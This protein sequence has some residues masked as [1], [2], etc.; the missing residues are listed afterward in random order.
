MA[1][2]ATRIAPPKVR[3]TKNLIDGKWVSAASGETFETFNPATGEVIAHVA[4]S[5]DED[6]DRA[7]KAARRAFESNTWAK[8]TGRDRGA[9]LYKLADLFEKHAEELAAL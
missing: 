1:T 3:Q 9:L 8:M 2:L 5:R 6:V 4:S 7:V